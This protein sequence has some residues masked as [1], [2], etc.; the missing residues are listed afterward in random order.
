MGGGGLYIRSQYD[1][2]DALYVLVVCACVCLKFGG[3]YDSKDNLMIV[4]FEVL[5]T[6]LYLLHSYPFAD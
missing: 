2:I 6:R 5:C 1:S 3:L 4:V